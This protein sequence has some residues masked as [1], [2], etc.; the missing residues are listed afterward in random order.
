MNKLY[1]VAIPVGKLW[2]NAYKWQQELND[3]YKMYPKEKLPPLHV[4]LEVFFYESMEQLAQISEVINK[5]MCASQGIY[6]KAAGFS[7]FSDPFKAINIHIIKTPQLRRLSK[8]LR[9]E[10]KK[11]GI[12]VRDIDENEIVYHMNLVGAMHGR[13]WTYDE[14]LEAWHYIRKH[15]I[16]GA[17]YAKKFELWFPDCNPNERK[18]GVFRV[19]F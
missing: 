1:L 13:D 8:S 2:E 18:A 3:K 5:V 9:E 12:K 15:L 16:E 17:F 10:S 11:S 14:A 4:T 19:G 7:F 6:F